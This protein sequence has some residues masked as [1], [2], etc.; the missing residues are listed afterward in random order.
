[1]LFYLEAIMVKELKVAPSIQQQRPTIDKEKDNY[2]K[3]YEACM[4]F[5]RVAKKFALVGM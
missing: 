2:P 5:L 1:V 3:N 4:E